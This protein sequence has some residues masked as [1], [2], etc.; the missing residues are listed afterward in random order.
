MGRKKLVRFTDNALQ[1]NVIEE[2]K[3]FFENC[4]GNWQAEHFGNTNPLVLELACGRGEYTVG[5][6]AIYPEKNFIGVDIKGAR[7]WKGSSIALEQGLTN[8]AFLR[9]YIQNLDHFFSP[10]EIQSIWII[11]PD[12][13]PRNKDAKRRL[14]HPRFLAMY[15]QLLSADG[16]VHLKTD[17]SGLFDYTLEVL[18]KQ[19]IKNLTFTRDLYSS[20]LAAA[21]HGIK[22]KYEKAFE[23]KGFTINYLK[24]QFQEEI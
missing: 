18:Q 6:A 24:F 4:K 5:L 20:L 12:P 17:N 3:P 7:I 2:G 14:T 16:Y 11:H 19:P 13:R 8:V 1:H 23:A 22:T 15:K 9:T 10:N 21:H